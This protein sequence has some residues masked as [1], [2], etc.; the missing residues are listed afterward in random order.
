MKENFSQLF[1]HPNLESQLEERLEVVSKKHLI[2]ILNYINFQDNTILIN[3]KHEKYDRILSLYAKPQP[4]LNNSLECLWTE[5]TGLNQTL[6]SYEFI[7]FLI[8]DG[9]KLI[10]VKAHLKD[11]NEKGITFELPDICFKVT[12]RKVRRYSCKGIKVQFV[13]NG[14]IFYGFLTDFSSISFGVEISCGPDQSFQWVNAEISVSITL[15]NERETLYSGNCEIIRQTCGQKK[16]VFVLKPTLDR[17]S[18]FKAKEFRSFRQKISHSPTLIFNHPLTN[19]IISLEI[20][21]ICGAG[22]SVEEKE[23]NSVLLAGMIIPELEIEFAGNPICKC[24]AQVIFRNKD[25]NGSV[26]SGITI[27]NMSIQ[28][29]VRLSNLLHHTKDEHSYVCNRVDPEALWKF[30][31]EAG[32]V[33]PKKYAFIQANKEKFKEIYEK[34]YNQNIDIARHFIYQDKGMILGHM[35]MVRFY[36]KTWMI[37]HHAARK[38][39]GKKAGLVVLEQVGRYVNDFHRLHS[40]HMNFVACYYRPENRFPNR[41][42]GGMA[43]ELKDPKGSSLDSFAY[44]HYPSTGSGQDRRTFEQQELPGS[45]A[46]VKTQP[47][48]LFELESFYEHKSGGLMF[49]ALDLDPSM[50]DVVEL[51]QE[52]HRFGFKRE[53]HLFSLKKDGELKAVIMVNVSDIGLNMSNLT[54]CIQVIVLDSDN[55]PQDILNLVLSQLSEYY[56]HDDIPVLLYPVTYAESQSIPCDKTYNLWVLNTQYLDHYF[57]FL[58]NLFH[59]A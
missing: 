44:F 34:L 14:I 4:C 22:F 57:K 2:D 15:A 38:A 56:D 27:L 19:S 10:L 20:I 52:Y 39:G 13:Q 30:F 49:S 33:Y 6:K 32:F 24:K 55:L 35:A 58:K 40:T 21:D 11:M 54:N 25:E 29:Q 45:W 23:E 46:L 12:S 8:S 42:F 18:R 48:D 16:R 28:D 5:T 43:R 41:V 3:L 59:S 17:V 31:F 36:E 1:P 9:L 26:R 50:I 7:N 37:H 53:R 47:E 51:S